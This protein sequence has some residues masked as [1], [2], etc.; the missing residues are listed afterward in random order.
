MDEAEK[1]NLFLGGFDEG[2]NAG[3]L[4]AAEFMLKRNVSA[5]QFYHDEI[6]K[7]RVKKKDDR[8]KS[9]DSG[10]HA[11]RLHGQ[12]GSPTSARLCYTDPQD[13]QAGG[14]MV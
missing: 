9:S 10:G 4:T 8:E 5:S 11:K 3:L 12:R 2:F 6:L 14:N 7:L 13:Q 1:L